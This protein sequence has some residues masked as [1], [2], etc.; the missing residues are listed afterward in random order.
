MSEITELAFGRFTPSPDDTI[1]VELLEPD[2]M[3]TMIRITS[4]GAATVCDPRRYA[5]IAAVAMRILAKAS[6]RYTQLRAQR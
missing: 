6:T 4:P 1:T 2:A 3:P 5:E